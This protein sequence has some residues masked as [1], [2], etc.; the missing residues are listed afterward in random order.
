MIIITDKLVPK[1]FGAITIGPFIFIREKHSAN[2]GLIAH[3]RHHQKQ[4]WYG[5][6]VIWFIRYFLDAKFRYQEELEAYRIE[7][8][9]RKI[10]PERAAKWLSHNYNVGVSYQRAWR[11]LN[12]S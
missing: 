1:G 2:D 8:T 10:L 5:L 4:Q 9:Y 7:L 11:D 3:E 12:A 6:N